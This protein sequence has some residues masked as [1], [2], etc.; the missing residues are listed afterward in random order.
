MS[1]QEHNP[2][3]FLIPSILLNIEVVLLNT[4][5]HKSMVEAPLN[6]PNDGVLVNSL[7][8]GQVTIR[9]PSTIY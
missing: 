2:K 3:S 9:Y 4:D 8:K 5:I 7:L 1:N 6:L